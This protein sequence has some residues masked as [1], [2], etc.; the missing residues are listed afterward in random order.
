MQNVCWWFVVASALEER[1]GL[2]AV[3]RVICDGV[4]DTWK[5]IP[6]NGGRDVVLGT[7]A[8]RLTFPLPRRLQHRGCRPCSAAFSRTELFRIKGF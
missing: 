1:I 5:S 4:T 7:K 3:T 8:S 6:M 2:F